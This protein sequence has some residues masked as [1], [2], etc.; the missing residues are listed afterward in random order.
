VNSRRYV[1]VSA[2]MPV[3]LLTQIVRAQP[4]RSVQTEV[5]LLLATIES[6]GCEFYRNGNWH[7]PKAAIAHLHDK[8]DYLVARN[9]INTT[10]DFI[11]R[12]AT[13]SS[14]SGQAYEV[15]CAGGPSVTSNQWLRERLALLRVHR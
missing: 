15:K 4:P 9:L 3:F 8:F 12:A 14:L 11:E 1:L 6:S 10:E 2:L 13:Q 7:G 5:D